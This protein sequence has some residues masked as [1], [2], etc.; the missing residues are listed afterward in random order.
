[1]L[2][3]G[4]TRAKAIGDASGVGAG[5]MDVSVG[6][7][8][9]KSFVL[10]VHAVNTVD[11]DDAIR[12]LGS[13]VAIRPAPIAREWH[14]LVLASIRSIPRRLRRSPFRSPWKSGRGPGGR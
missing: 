6:R 12:L 14:H 1:M 5:R 4:G 13:T 9:E 10:P 2:Y 11:A 7:R 8:G 3:P